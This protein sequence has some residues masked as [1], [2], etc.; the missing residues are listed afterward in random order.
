MALKF[1]VF[2]RVFFEFL[3]VN[4]VFFRAVRAPHDRFGVIEKNICLG[5]SFQ[6]AF[7]KP[8]VI[9]QSYV[10]FYKRH[11][12]SIPPFITNSI[13][14]FYWYKLYSISSLG[15]SVCLCTPLDSVAKVY[16]EKGS[17]CFGLDYTVCLNSYWFFLDSGN[18]P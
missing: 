6:L 12:F 8:I 3:G 1:W 14:N 7:L 15:F 4:E 16:I 11:R 9:K 18:S 10:E 17:F 5:Q 2:G 13:R